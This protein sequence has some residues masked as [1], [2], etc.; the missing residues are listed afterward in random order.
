MFENGFAGVELGFLGDFSEAVPRADGEA[1]V[2]AVDAVAHQGAEFEGDGAFVLDGEVGD[3]A[4]SIHGVG[5]SDRLGGAGVDAGG[6]LATM[7][8][9]RGVGGKVES[10]EEVGEEEPST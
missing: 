3:A 4:P 8:G 2:A 5:R 10:C 6:A 9:L 7:V 1:V